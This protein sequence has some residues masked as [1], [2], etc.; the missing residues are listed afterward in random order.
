MTRRRKPGKSIS[1]RFGDLFKADDIENPEGL[2]RW[3]ASKYDGVPTTTKPGEKGFER[4]QSYLLALKDPAAQHNKGK[5]N[6][7]REQV[8][9]KDNKPVK[10]EKTGKIKTRRIKGKLR[11]PTRN[12]ETGRKYGGPKSHK[13]RATAARDNHG[14]SYHDAAD[15]GFKTP[16]SSHRKGGAT[17]A[18]K[19]LGPREDVERKQD[20]KVKRMVRQ[21]E[22]MKKQMPNSELIHKQRQDILERLEKLV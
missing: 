6:R 13:Q 17:I 16:K 10:D 22:S 20:K 2:A 12:K 14:W 8:K 19:H 9:D 5:V 15:K 21:A 4:I 3:L 7:I 18:D 1:Q 11:G